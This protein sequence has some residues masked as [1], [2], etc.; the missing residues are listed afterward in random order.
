MLLASGELAASSANICMNI[1]WILGDKLPCVSF[2]ERVNN[3]L[4]CSVRPAHEN[5]FLDRCVEQNGLLLDITNLFSQ[6]T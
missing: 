5:I 4:I 1:A 3:L 2:F 6:L